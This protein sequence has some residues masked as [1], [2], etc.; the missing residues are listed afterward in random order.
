MDDCK[1]PGLPWGASGAHK[2]LPSI[3]WLPPS[4]PPDLG[5]GCPCLDIEQ[6]ER[7]KPGSF[8]RLALVGAGRCQPGT[9]LWGGGWEMTLQ[10]EGG[11]CTSGL[12]ERGI[13]F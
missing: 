4:P 6:H 12:R 7:G 8:S 13:C 10:A 11:G 5:S 2:R 3:P 9:V 1:G